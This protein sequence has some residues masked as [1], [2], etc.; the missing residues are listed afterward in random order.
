MKNTTLSAPRLLFMTKI[1]IP[2]SILPADGRFGSGPS[3]ISPAQLDHLV[4]HSSLLG[5]SH[6]QPPVKQ[7]VGRVREA[8]ASYFDLPSDYEV[9]LGNGGSTA[10]WDIAA[11][12]LVEKKSAHLVFG[13]FGEKCARAH[14]TPWLEV[15]S[16]FSSE[17]GNLGSLIAEPGVDLYAWPHNETSTGVMAPVEKLQGAEPGALMMV[18]GTSA[19]GGLEFKVSE[20]DIYYFAPQKNFA[21]DGGIWFAL[22]SPEAVARA[23]AVKS[24]GRYIPNFLSLT[25]A[26]E[27]SRENQTLNTPSITTLLLM[28]AQLDW[29]KESGGFKAVTKR[30]IEVSQLLYDWA[31][32]NPSFRPFV[33]NPDHRSNVVVTLDLDGKTKAGQLTK[34]LRDNGILDIDPYRKLG[35]N[36][37]RV[38]TFAGVPKSDIEKLIDSIEFAM[39]RL[40]E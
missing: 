5:T 17:P 40:Q 34:V 20:T 27:N 39:S 25:N 31:E 29:L 14:K 33:T 16:I 8:L 18:D 37:I 7:L 32:S 21:S 9:V 24:T 26:I 4:Q 15:P 1:S 36:Q 38:A 22:L 6:R 10:F 35:R 12:S 30:C 2:R 23:Y 13:E 11:F 3:R 28:E 19:A